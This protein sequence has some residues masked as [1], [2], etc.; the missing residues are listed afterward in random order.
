MS[1]Q[2]ERLELV[3]K[4]I[5]RKAIAGE[6]TDDELN[7]AV[8]AIT[9]IEK[10][11]GTTA[12]NFVAP[13]A[14]AAKKATKGAK[15][16]ASAGK[17]ATGAGK[18]AASG[19]KKAASSSKKLKLKR[20]Q[21]YAKKAEDTAAD[22]AA[23]ASAHAKTQATQRSAKIARG[24]APA[25]KASTSA[26]NNRANTASANQSASTGT[27]GMGSAPSSSFGINMP[28]MDTAKK[29]GSVA[30]PL[31]G[32]A[33]IYQRSKQSKTPSDG[34]KRIRTQEGADFYGGSIGDI[35]TAEGK[36]VKDTANQ[37]LND[38]NSS[39][40]AKVLGNAAKPVAEAAEATGPIASAIEHKVKPKIQRRNL[41][42]AGDE[43]QVD[44]GMKRLAGHDARNAKTPEEARDSLLIPRMVDNEFGV[45]EPKPSNFL[46]YWQSRLPDPSLTNLHAASGATPPSEGVLMD[47]NGQMMAQDVGH[48]DDHYLPFKGGKVG[49]AKGGEYVRTRTAGGLTTED[50]IAAGKSNLRATTVVSHSGI[51]T[52][53]FYP[54]K[55]IDTDQIQSRY[56]KLLDSLAKE[57][58]QKNPISP[59]RETEIYEKA[60]EQIPGITSLAVDRRRNLIEDMKRAE[61]D[62]PTPAAET[63]DQWRKEFLLENAEKFS[64]PDG[65][66]YTA[67]RIIEDSGKYGVEMFSDTDAIDR[68]G[69]GEKY[70]K[71]E[72]HKMREYQSSLRALRLN[73]EGYDKALKAL[74]EQFPYQIKSVNW[75]PPDAQSAKIEDLGYVKANFNRPD[76]VQEGYHDKEIEGEPKHRASQTDFQNYRNRVKA[77]QLGKPREEEPK[78]EKTDPS[79]ADTSGLDV[80][81]DTSEDPE[82]AGRPNPNEGQMAPADQ[83]EEARV[84]VVANPAGVSY[85]GFSTMAEQPQSLQFTPYQ[86]NIKIS[87]IR[88][89]IKNAGDIEYTDEAGNAKVYDPWDE[90]KNNSLRS[91]YPALFSDDSDAEFMER[92]G[93]DEKFRAK[94][95]QN[96]DDLQ[97]TGSNSVD[98][99]EAAITDKVG[100]GFDGIA[101]NAVPKNPRSAAALISYVGKPM[102]E[103]KTYDFTSG[104]IDGKYY[105]PGLEKDEYESVWG[106]DPDIQDYLAKQKA[107]KITISAQPAVFERK[108]KA[109]SQAMDEALEKA[110]QWEEEAALRG[111]YSKVPQEAVAYD[112]RDFTPY[113]AKDLQEQVASDALA[114]AK[115]KQL[116]QA[117]TKAD[118]TTTKKTE[119]GFD[120][121]SRSLN[122][123]KNPKDFDFGRGAPPEEELV[124]SSE[125][126]ADAA[127]GRVS[128][129]EYER[130][131]GKAVEG[132]LRTPNAENPPAPAPVVDEKKLEESK[133][134]LEGLTGLDPVKE[135]FN[136]LIDDARISARRKALGLPVREKSMNLVFTGNPGTGKTTVADEIAN[137]YHALGLIPEAKRKT[138]TRSDLVGEYSGQTAVK[139]RKVLEEAK[140]GV[141]FIDE[142]YALKNGEQ[143]DFG[144]EAIDEIV[145]HSEQ[146]KGDTVMI[147]AGYG[148][149]MKEMMG[150]NAGMKSRFPR[151]IDFPDYKPSELSAI[152][153]NSAKQER[154]EYTDKAMD[155]FQAG[156]EMIYSSELNGNARDVRN[157]Q[158][159][160]TRA[161][162]ARIQREI[163]AD[164][165]NAEQMK[166][167][168]ES[169]V[170]NAAELYFN[171]RSK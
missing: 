80:D 127:A 34:K 7:E 91:D 118:G 130:D 138:V 59:E 159:A 56:G 100:S 69:L 108:M 117:F 141:L 49:K 121:Y 77:A 153:H 35:I 33:S 95:M 132:D 70:K 26:T 150:Q 92:L 154:Y 112:G 164:N 53:E 143:D 41:R 113:T 3:K 94:V 97:K 14:K 89:K 32:A 168:T 142:A 123:G 61:K 52:M 107:G 90:G 115:M 72:T 21:K 102:K 109:R 111:D 73:G 124:G 103:G 46:R 67:E 79:G 27:G 6:L 120:A 145:A 22:A 24:D 29:I 129:E 65:N 169:D 133:Q 25:S 125:D 155:A 147:L 148:D 161:Q 126:V 139:T 15:K 160:I 85:Q 88:K 114:L 104:G 135:E 13:G 99:I 19:T 12:L 165:A 131:G 5:T 54:G 81:I 10:A 66:P 82:K 68:L 83:P 137:S 86:Q 116:R 146:N 1:T 50:I 171:Q 30:G 40:G 76:K 64:D 31:V 163:G 39:P 158:D 57:K 17:K 149:D 8:A 93:S 96:I 134:K 45:S 2:Q 87:D 74:K 156:T 11:A 101:S 37:V 110:N 170:M 44:P 23:K 105:M 75:T 84:G 20:A 151:T 122:A 157:F 166:E 36:A 9:A 152:G 128:D 18:K 51:F 71:Y 4:S 60:R 78:K 42:R 58:V 106:M 48:G 162:G 62:N 167:V 98:G 38:E 16:A 28:G 43:R 63:K 140:G 47:V 119:A 136:T 144:Q 55:E